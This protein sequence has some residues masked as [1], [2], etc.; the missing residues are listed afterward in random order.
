MSLPHLRLA[1]TVATCAA[2]E[3]QSGRRMKFL[4]QKLGQG[5]L[6]VRFQGLVPILPVQHQIFICV[7][8]SGRGREGNST[9]L[10]SCVILGPGEQLLAQKAV[11]NLLNLK[12]REDGRVDT[13]SSPAPRSRSGSP[14][15]SG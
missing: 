3:G 13:Y 15:G 14:G 5:D 6:V 11:L 9:P 12:G 10:L 8:I 1:E 7:C 4:N 2:V